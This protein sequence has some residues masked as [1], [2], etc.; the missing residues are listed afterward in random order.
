MKALFSTKDLKIL[1][2]HKNKI[3]RNILL[4]EVKKL[5]RNTNDPAQYERSVYNQWMGFTK[6]II[7]D[8]NL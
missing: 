8:D 3:G 5:I 1:K 4:D 7:Q 6:I 2:N